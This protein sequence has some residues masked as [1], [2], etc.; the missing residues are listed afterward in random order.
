MRSFLVYN[1]PSFIYFGE[2]AIDIRS[3]AWKRDSLMGLWPA[4]LAPLYASL[5]D[6]RDKIP[7]Q[8]FHLRSFLPSSWSID[9]GILCWKGSSGRTWSTPR[10]RTYREWDVLEYDRLCLFHVRGNRM[11]SPNHERNRRH[12]SISENCDRGTVH[13]MCCLRGIRLYLL[14]RMGRHS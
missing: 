5:L 10:F 8:R 2:F 6:P 13:L 9:N 4:H 12:G 1:W 11:P 3:L 14:L 7:I